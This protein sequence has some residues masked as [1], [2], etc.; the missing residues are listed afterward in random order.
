MF[1]VKSKHDKGI[2][3]KVT[4]F[5][6]S[7]LFVSAAYAN[8]PPRGT[9]SHSK[10][11]MLVADAETG[12]VLYQK[13]AGKYRYPASLTKLMTLYLTFEAIE[14]GRLSLGKRIR[15]SSN[16][17][18]QSPSRLGLKRGQRI[19]VKDA[20]MSLIVKSAN[21]S[22]VVLAEAIGGTES[23]FA[24][25]MTRKAKAL[26]MRHTIFRNASGLPNSR[27]KTT[28]YDMTR[29]AMA[30]KR[31]FPKYYPWFAKK[32]FRYK[33]RRVVSH[34]RVL[35]KY[36]GATGLKTGYIRASGFNIVTT[37]KR[38]N[39]ELIA[40]ILGGKTAKHR[41][42]YTM[43]MLDRGFAKLKKQYPK[44]DFASA[45][46]PQFKP[47]QGS[48]DDL[49]QSGGNTPSSSPLPAIP[50]PSPRPFQVIEDSPIPKKKPLIRKKVS[51]MKYQQY[52][53]APMF[54]PV[55]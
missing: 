9:F 12:T 45:P 27:Q 41:D 31:D 15:V 35:K 22:A 49:P 13:N 38:G 47:I 33:G 52:V 14:T 25:L 16:A 11:A 54:K 48:T 1:Q 44:S 6:V 19:S 5:L 10:Y 39:R 29:L 7:F 4:I 26:G 20:A 30:L 43:K 37:A 32:E 23:D 2:F 17:A 28:A 42:R 50:Q 24:L 34:N 53:P 8:N 55:R 36:R 18:S 51:K 3:F 46:I 40:V 21:D